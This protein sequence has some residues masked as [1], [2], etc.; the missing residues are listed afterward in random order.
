MNKKKTLK[1]RDFLL[2]KVPRLKVRNEKNL[3]NFDTQKLFK[4]KEK[5]ALALFECLVENDTQA[6]M[7]I[8]DA[9]LRI[10]RSQVAQNADMARSTVSL[11]FSNKG[12]PTLKTIAKMVHEAARK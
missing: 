11:A 1:K 2:S 4:N 9:F 7:E 10:N 8:L 5:V 6:F 12:N 3:A